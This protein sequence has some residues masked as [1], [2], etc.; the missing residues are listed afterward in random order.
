MNMPMK[1]KDFTF[2][3]NPR[4]LQVVHRGKTATLHCPGRGGLTQHLGS[5]C[6]VVSGEGDFFGAEASNRLLTLTMMASEDTS[7]WLTLP[8]F[9]PF[10]AYLTRLTFLGEG[11]GSV[12]SYSFEFVEAEA[13]STG[14]LS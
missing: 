6:R 8:G 11:D 5:L 3:H 4:K 10:Q 2:P 1:Y 9:P 14:R 13:S 7:G 12:L